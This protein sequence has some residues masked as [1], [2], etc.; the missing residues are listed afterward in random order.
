MNNHIN[1]TSILN[2]FTTQEGIENFILNNHSTRE[3]VEL[4]QRI[5]S[6]IDNTELKDN[7][8]LAIQTVILNVDNISLLKEAFPKES[9]DVINERRRRLLQDVI[10]K[11]KND[12]LHHQ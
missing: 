9:V 11:T 8:S 10:T 3:G 5:Y 12:Y 4:L 1:K 2:D 6:N 7:F